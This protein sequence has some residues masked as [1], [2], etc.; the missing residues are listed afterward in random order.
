M[1]TQWKE[2]GVDFFEYVMIVAFLIVS[3]AVAL[4]GFAKDVGTV[5]S[6]VSTTV[7]GVRSR[8]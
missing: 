7:N 1:Q 2:R 3:A 5:V 8:V 6:K 4:P